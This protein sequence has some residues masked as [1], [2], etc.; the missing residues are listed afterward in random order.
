MCQSS[1]G[2]ALNQY[3]TLDIS[4]LVGLSKFFSISSSGIV[5]FSFKTPT[6]CTVAKIMEKKG[7]KG[8]SRSCGNSSPHTR[9]LLCSLRGCAGCLPVANTD[10]AVV[11]AGQARGRARAPGSGAAKLEVWAGG[12]L[13]WPL[14]IAGV[15][16]AVNLHRFSQ[17]AC[18]SHHIH[19]PVP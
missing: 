16:F 7:K 14:C 19:F 17:I 2:T 10:P 18:Q 15:R 1:T 9:R 3:R 11:A 8:I 13:H 5:S 12:G 4:F 6:I